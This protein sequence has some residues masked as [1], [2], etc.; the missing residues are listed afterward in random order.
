MKIGNSVALAC[1]VLLTGCTDATAPHPAPE[2]ICQCP[3]PILPCVWDAG[4][5]YLCPIGAP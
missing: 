5:N 1:L 4:I 2:T 3:P